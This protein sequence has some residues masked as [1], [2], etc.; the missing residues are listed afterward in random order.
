MSYIRVAKDPGFT[1]S[2]VYRY[3]SPSQ[4]DKLLVASGSHTSQPSCTS[5]TNEPPNCKKDFDWN[6]MVNFKRNTFKGLCR[7]EKAWTHN[8][9]VEKLERLE[10]KNV[11][12]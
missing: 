5:R 8:K 11:K 9:N 2:L 4:H 6:M 10:L 3:N 7:K 12:P 1:H